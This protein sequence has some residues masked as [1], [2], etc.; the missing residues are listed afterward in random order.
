MTDYNVGV[1]NFLQGFPF[2]VFI[3]FAIWSLIWKGLVL[4]VTARRNLSGWFIF[5]LI[6]NTAGI[7]EVIYLLATK[8]FDELKTSKEK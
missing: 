5:F 6:V 1:N 7:I 4:W 3:V 8:G 2:G